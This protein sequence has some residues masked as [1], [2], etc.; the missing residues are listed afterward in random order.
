[1]KGKSVIEF[2]CGEGSCGIVLS[3]LGV[4]YHGVDIAPTA[5]KKAEKRLHGFP[6]VSFEHLDMVKEMPK[7]KYDAALDV[8]G[9]HMLITDNQRLCYLKNA[10]GCLKKNAPMLFFRENYNENAAENVIESLEQFEEMTGTDYKTP[11]KRIMNGKEVYLPTL[12]ARARS[13][14]GYCSELQKA[15]FK[16]EKFG[17][18]AE[19]T[20]IVS[21][22]DIYVRKI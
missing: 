14:R 18:S 4:I 19:N 9:I 13:E 5:L 7:G 10:C 21:G 11:Q 8:M 1:M 16:V 2:A 6:N 22:A 12:P 17:I 15:G 3:H 20:S